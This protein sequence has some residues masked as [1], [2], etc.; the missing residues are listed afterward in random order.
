MKL[1]LGPWAGAANVTSAPATGLSFL[2]V[3]VTA[4]RIAKRDPAAVDSVAA[5]PATTV[6][7]RPA[8]FYNAGSGEIFGETQPAGAS[9]RD[10]FR[11]QSPYA[12]AKAAAFW[13]VANYRQAYGIHANT[14]ILFNHE[15]PLRPARFVTR[16][17]IA[18]ACRISRGSGEKLTLG[19]MGI[20]RDW[21]SRR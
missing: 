3:T 13:L 21:G 7:G 2:S 16:K 5:T 12:V 15:S 17:I 20:R 11:P 9:E 8:R 1:P 4:R 10:P 14:G 18:A 6:L 19:N